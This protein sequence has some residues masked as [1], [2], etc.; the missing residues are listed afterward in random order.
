MAITRYHPPLIPGTKD[1]MDMDKSQSG[2][3]VEY[4]EFEQKIKHLEQKL[5]LVTKDRD[6]LREILRWGQK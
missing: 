2:R 4:R 3:F 6:R 5:E 1:H